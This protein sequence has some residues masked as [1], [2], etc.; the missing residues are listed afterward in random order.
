MSNAS[1][2][3]DKYADVMAEQTRVQ[4][5]QAELQEQA[6]EMQAAAAREQEA[7]IARMERQADAVRQLMEVMQ[8]EYDRYQDQL[9]NINDRISD[10][11]GESYEDTLSETDKMSQ[12]EL[13]E[14]LETDWS[15]KALKAKSIAQLQYYLHKRQL[16]ADYQ[17]VKL[18]SSPI[19]PSQDEFWYRVAP[20]L[21]DYGAPWGFAKGT[22]SAPG[23]LS[24]VGEKGPELRVLD[25]GD[26][27]LPSSITSNL[28]SWGK[29][30]PTAI[31]G[32][33]ASGM[34]GGLTF[35]GA[36]LSFPNVRDG[37][38]AKSF[39]TN[40]RNMAYQYAFSR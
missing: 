19:Y 17:G 18:G 25:N 38:D 30:D 12:S 40:L 32:K 36:S 22:T 2:F 15:S 8:D 23:G 20:S 35:N 14:L 31:F 11:R 16:K 13:K 7:V 27:I 10:T 24:L 1:K 9:D 26:G 28:W 37:N 39:V 29:L 34:T 33:L 3:A 6:A 5:K 21:G 4:Q